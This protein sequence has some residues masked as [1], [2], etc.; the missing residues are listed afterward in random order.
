MTGKKEALSQLQLKHRR[1]LMHCYM[2][3]SNLCQHATL[4]ENWSQVANDAESNF[5]KSHQRQQLNNHQPNH[6]P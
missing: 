5:I 1:K 6:A 3:S 4:C 2:G